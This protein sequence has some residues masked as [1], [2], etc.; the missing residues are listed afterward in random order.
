MRT[1]GGCGAIRA[2]VAAAMLVLVGGCTDMDQTQE[3]AQR[4]LANNELLAERP[5]SEDMVSRYT[6]MQAE[7]MDAVAAVVPEVRWEPRRAP[8][9]SGCGDHNPGDGRVVGLQP[10]GASGAIPAER[11]AVALDAVT[12]VVDRYGFG[13]PGVK[14]SD[15]GRDD[16]QVRMY[17]AV[18][19]YVDFGSYVDVVLAVHTGCALPDAIRTQLAPP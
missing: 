7:I 10:W 5:S 16:R 8:S 11:W 2:G 18:G 1:A 12:T 4:R 9:A 17:D 6:R 3:W 15:P 19:G 13:A 14:V